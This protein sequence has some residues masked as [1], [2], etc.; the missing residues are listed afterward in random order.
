VLAGHLK[1]DQANVLNDARALNS[2]SR[3][4]ARREK[5]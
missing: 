1:K 2:N 3:S 4:L 5:I